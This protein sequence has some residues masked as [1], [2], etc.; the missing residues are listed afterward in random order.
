MDKKLKNRTSIVTKVKRTK[1]VEIGLAGICMVL[2]GR[3]I[4]RPVVMR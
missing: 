1:T 2:T 3:A 4:V